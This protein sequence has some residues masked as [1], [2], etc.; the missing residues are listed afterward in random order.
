MAREGIFAPL[1]KTRMILL[2]LKTW[3]IQLDKRIFTFINSEAASPHADSLM[4]A[5]RN[6]LTWIPLYAFILYWVVRYQK[7]IAWQFILLSLVCFAIADFTCFVILKPFFARPRPCFDPGLQ[8]TIRSLVGCGG[9]FG[10]PSNHASNHF[11]LA[12]FWFLSVKKISGRNWQWLWMWA[13]LVCY[14]QVY[15]GKH[16]PFD[17]M[18]GGL[19]GVMVG[20][21]VFQLFKRIAVK[22]PPMHA[23][24]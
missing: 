10:M 22:K 6:P 4:L 11:A 20:V 14:A 12:T 21:L 1:A 16:F 8:A 13:A 23:H 7:K 2:D 19:L 3:L 17:V 9:R 15:V 18:T 24:Q 5:L